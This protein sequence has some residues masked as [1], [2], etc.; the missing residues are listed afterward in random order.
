MVDI[1]QRAHDLALL[2]MQMEVNE[3]K[4]KTEPGEDYVNFF[5]TYK[6]HFSNLKELIEVTPKQ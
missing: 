6:K 1:E 3:G 5:E 4:L 2:Y